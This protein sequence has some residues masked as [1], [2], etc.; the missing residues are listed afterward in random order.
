MK[1]LILLFLLISGCD[2]YFEPGQAI[3]AGI[4]AGLDPDLD[5]DGDGVNNALDNC[6]LDY[7]PNQ[8]D[9]DLDY[10]GDLCD[11]CPMSSTC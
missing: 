1:I 4:D 5:Q 3:D 6:P 7:N 10:V 8:Q 2:L 9:R 11:P